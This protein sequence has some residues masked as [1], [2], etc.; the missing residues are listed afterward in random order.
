MHK[1]GQI[2]IFIIIG[3]IIVFAGILYFV[4]R[5]NSSIESIPVEI[6]PIESAFLSCLEEKLDLG[7]RVMG[8]KGGYIFNPPLIDGSVYQPFSSQLD[9][10]GT[11]I[12]YW[13]YVQG[14]NIESSQ[15]PTK[16][17]MESELND[18]MA[19]NIGD[20]NLNEF[21]DQGYS[22]ELG[23]PEIKT[24]INEN[25]I[26]LEISMPLSV[27]KDFQ[28]TIITKHDF[29]FDSNLGLLYDAAT[30]I[31]QRELSQSFLENYS[32]DVMRMNL[33]VDGFKLACS[34]LKWDANYLVSQFKDSLEMNTI[35][36][37]NRG[38]KDD[39]YNIDFSN[40]VDL[41]FIYDQNWPTYFE[42]NP[43]E[44]DL[45]IAKPIG[46]ASE[47]GILGFCYVPYHFVYDIRHPVLIQVSKGEE[48]FQFPLLVIIDGN[49]AKKSRAEESLSFAE[50]S[51]ICEKMN[52]GF[53]TIN[54][55]DEDLQKI[56][57]AEITF[58]CFDSSCKLGETIEGVYSGSIP[59]CVNG[60]LKISAPGYEL[61]ED[62]YTTIEETT[63]FSILEKEYTKEINLIVN[64]KNYDGDALISFSSKTGSK[65]LYYPKEKFV[66]ISSNDYGVEVYLMKNTSISFPETKTE[67][68]YSVPRSGVLGIVGFM[69]KECEEVVIPEQTINGAIVGGD[70]VNVSFNSNDV[71][72]FEI[73]EI[74]N[75]DE[76][77][78]KSLDD[79][80]NNYA[81]L[82]SG[83]MEVKLK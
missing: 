21:S 80:Q 16:E 14:S 79:V 45:L 3:I 32:I 54:V 28:T 23:V 50:Q 29:E 61:Y 69:K 49:V 78:P 38:E 59:Q 24:H 77:I 48:I 42:V 40:N 36:L 68:C 27:T 56:D 63:I 75:L 37:N 5:D 6:Q 4:L 9:F 62:I 66:N 31:Y 35:L 22:I 81:L 2:T 19:R 7:V 74:S 30:N 55:Y 73:I 64:G 70:S 25:S 33:P 82:G 47:L 67:Q 71:K 44:N 52:L 34:P 1:K 65:F 13:Y 46:D 18:Y 11:Q 83:L 76:K 17:F 43:A 72:N 39:Y 41:R 51:G 26:N 60:V 8:A 10:V 57:G 20:C 12:P 15:F 53:T 58:D